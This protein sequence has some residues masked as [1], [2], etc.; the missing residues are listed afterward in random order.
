MKNKLKLLIVPLITLVLEILPYGAVCNFAVSDAENEITEI[1]SLYSYFDL[2]PFGYANFGPL[3]CALTTCIIIFLLLINCLSNSKRL[4][5]IIR[6]IIVICLFFSLM[7]L[8]YGVRY[9]SIIGI[10]ISCSLVI[11]LILI[12]KSINNN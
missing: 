1:R 10:L 8:L 5:R 2:V 3:L 4:S 12:Q 9:F 6:T 7:P 11:E